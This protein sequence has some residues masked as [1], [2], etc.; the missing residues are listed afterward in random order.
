MT[1]GIV[2]GSKSDLPTMSAAIEILD[3]LGISYEV[4]ILSAHRTPKETM[5]WA[6]TAQSRGHTVL[7]CGAGMAAHLAGVVAAH[8]HL[9]V[10]GVPINASL[11]GVDALLAT[12]QMP[13]GVPVAT[14]GVGR[15]GA[16]NASWLAAKIM[17]VSDPKLRSKLK[18]KKDQMRRKVLNDDSSLEL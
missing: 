3:D 2:M 5:E 11:G 17:A 1:I 8:T 13:P 7:I 12:V 9:P 4:R 18:E 15:A 10:I 14:V 16:K 6:E